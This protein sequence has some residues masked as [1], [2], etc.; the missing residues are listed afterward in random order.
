[1]GENENKRITSI[2]FR[3]NSTDYE[4]GVFDPGN[5]LEAHSLEPCPRE[6]KLTITKGFCSIN[7]FPFLEGQ[8]VVISAGQSVDI[9][10][11]SKFAYLCE[12]D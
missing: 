8:T 6:R 2:A 3:N 12:Y 11:T 1:M 7:C 5:D 9:L 4:I 10:A